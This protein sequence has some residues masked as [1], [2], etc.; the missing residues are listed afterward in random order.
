M[1]ILYYK[2][3]TDVTRYLKFEKIQTNNR[4]EQAN[5]LT[6]SRRKLLKMLVKCLIRFSVTRF[7]FWSFDTVMS[8]EPVEWVFPTPTI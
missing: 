6:D 7:D 3:I 5:L 4:G 1:H 8:D 2:S